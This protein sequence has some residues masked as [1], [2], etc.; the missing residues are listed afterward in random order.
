MRKVITK[1]DVSITM[2]S[3]FFLILSFL[4]MTNYML[5]NNNVYYSLNIKKPIEEKKEK[6]WEFELPLNGS[7]GYSTIDIKLKKDK[8][9]NSETITTIKRGVSFTVLDE[10]DNWWQINYQGK[11]GWIDN[12]FCM[13]NLPDIIPSIIYDASNSYSS[14]FKS[15]GYDIPNITDKKL[16]DV[17]MYNYRLEKDEF[18]MPV[19]YPMA[20]KIN[21]AQQLALKNGDSLKIYESY[22]P[23]ETQRSV[24]INLKE[25]TATNAK[26]YNGIN[27]NSWSE[28]W[29]IYNGLSN[30][31]LGVAIDVSLVKINTYI[32]K[33]IGSYTYIDITNYEEYSMPSPMH[34]LSAQAV[35]FKYGV[36]PDS[37]TAWKNVPL[38]DNITEGAVK[39]QNYC[40]ESGLTPISSEWWHFNDLDSKDMIKGSSSKGDYYLSGCSS[41]KINK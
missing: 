33:E 9:I 29:F 41:Q 13:I 11:K 12:T 19:L 7:S 34:E 39:L 20:K 37:K 3:L 38:V 6:D 36:S 35:T 1:K 24:V 17:K 21:E 15:S 40:V 28:T 30:H 26:V 5:K 10:K 14:L 8:N 27:I 16:Y 32:V 2:I 25:L 18:V 22:R 23:R 31:Q 4:A